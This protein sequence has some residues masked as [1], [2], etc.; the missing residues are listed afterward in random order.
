MP[1][2]D[3][4][5]NAYALPVRDRPWIR[6]NFVSSAD[7]AVTLGGRT[8]GLGGPTDRLLMGVL[9]TMADV[10]LVGA[11][12]VRNEGYGGLGL[13]PD[14]LAW[15]R[16]HQLPD[17]PRLAI[18]SNRLDLEPDSPVFAGVQDRPIVFTNAMAAAAQQARLVHVA[19]VVSCGQRSVDLPTVVAELTGRGLSQILCEGGPHLFGSLLASDLVDEL[20][21]TISPR[22]VAGATS[23][24]ALSEHE[25][26]R[27]FAL[28]SALTDDDGFV[29]LRYARSA[30]TGQTDR[31]QG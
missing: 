25:L 14:D 16:A 9:R 27:P 20:C 3:E 29:F 21:L 23:R 12:T 13:G 30:L 28:A 18:V 24:I 17:S 1:T 2:R 31:R 19:E 11:G 22:L 4:L 7:G 10:V 26:D 15:R 8:A 6:A 5:F